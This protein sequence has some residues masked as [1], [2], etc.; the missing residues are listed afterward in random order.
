M[1]G[2]KVDRFFLILIFILLAFGIVLGL[3]VFALEAARGAVG[4]PHQRHQQRAEGL[5]RGL[6]Q[7]VAPAAEVRSGTRL[8]AP[9]PQVRAGDI[10]RQRTVPKRPLPSRRRSA[11]AQLPAWSRLPSPEHGSP[12]A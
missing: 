2:K 1:Q 3:V 7:A 12:V 11:T 5:H 9:V 6:R 4:Q 10:L 8:T